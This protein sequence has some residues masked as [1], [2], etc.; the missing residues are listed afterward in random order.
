MAKTLVV[1]ITGSV[2]KPILK[3]ILDEEEGLPM[4]K[5]LKQRKKSTIIVEEGLI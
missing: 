4:V 5:I 3:R 1:I 2:K